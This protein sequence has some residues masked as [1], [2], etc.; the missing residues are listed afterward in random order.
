MKPA[1]TASAVAQG[2]RIRGVWHG[3]AYIEVHFVM[4]DSTA[5]Y[6]EPFNV[7]NVMD[8]G[9]GKVTI[10]RDVA[11]VLTALQAWAAK[12]YPGELATYRENVSR[13]AG[14]RA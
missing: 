10:T 9:T 1:W 7:I 6:P 12:L 4:P 2:E 8:Y 3:G 11:G 14:G 13:D 5:R